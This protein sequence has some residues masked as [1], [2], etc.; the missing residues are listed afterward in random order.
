MASVELAQQKKF[1]DI[2]ILLN[3]K[4]IVVKIMSSITA[5]LGGGAIGREG[6]TLQIS[7]SIFQ[8]VAK[9]GPFLKRKIDLRFYWLVLLL[10]LH[11]PSI[12]LSGNCLRH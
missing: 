2:D 9:N 10:V 7:S 1:A 12:L 11:P 6:P 8:L 5:G 4:I 3:F